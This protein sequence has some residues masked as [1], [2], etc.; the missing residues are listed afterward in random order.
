MTDQPRH[1]VPLPA[2]YAD[3]PEEQKREFVRELIGTISPPEST[4]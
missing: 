1:Y 2:G 4:D 3:W